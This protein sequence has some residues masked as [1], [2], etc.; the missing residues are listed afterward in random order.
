MTSNRGTNRGS[1]ITGRSVH[2]IRIE[3]LYRDVNRVVTSHYSAIF[4]HMELYGILDSTSELDMFV[5][6]YVFLPRIANSLEEFT[7]QWNY[8][9]IRTVGNT[10]PLALWSYGM[11]SLNA[12]DDMVGYL[13]SNIMVLIMKQPVRTFRMMSLLFPRTSFISLMKRKQSCFQTLVH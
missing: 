11:V 13:H 3:R 6:H 9:G 1:F 5:L 7:V 8:H 12:N 2:N 4:K 10:S